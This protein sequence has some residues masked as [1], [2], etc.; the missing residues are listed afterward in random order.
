MIFFR[1]RNRGSRPVETVTAGV[2]RRGM[3]KPDRLALSWV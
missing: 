3:R 2:T 1:Q